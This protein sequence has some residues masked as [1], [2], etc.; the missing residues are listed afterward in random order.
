MTGGLI[1]WRPAGAAAIAKT[2]HIDVADPS[3]WRLPEDER[4]ADR[5]RAKRALQDFRCGEDVLQRHGSTSMP[6][7]M[8][9]G[10]PSLQRRWRK[11]MA[12]GFDQDRQRVLRPIRVG[13][14]AR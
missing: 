8:L 11:R 1:A 7:E 5:I 6:I 4:A 12:G 13:T 2:G 14:A 9:C 10:S 3:C